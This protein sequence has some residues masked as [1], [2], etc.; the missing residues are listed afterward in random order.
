LPQFALAFL[1]LASAPAAD[2]IVPPPAAPVAVAPAALPAPGPAPSDAAPAAVAG[3]PAP[4]P[5]A[6]PGVPDAAA[7]L[8]AAPDPAAIVV[9]SDGGDIVV[10]AKHEAPREDPLEGVNIQSYEAVQAVDRAIVAP[11][12]MGYKHVIPK[13]VRNGISN[14]INNLDEPVV[15]LNYLLQLKPGKAAETLGRFAINSTIGV[16]G[17][18]DVAK[19][20]PFNL[21][22]RYNGLANTLGFY[23]IGPGPFLFLPGIG[24]TTVR[25]LFG[26]VADF[27][28][29]PRALGSPLTD[30]KY[31]LPKATLTAIS[32]R[33]DDDARITALRDHTADG[34][35]SI[36]KFYLDRRQAEIDAL[37]GKTKPA[38]VVVSVT[39]APAPAAAPAA[40]APKP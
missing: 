1:L 30:T 14:F 29:I 20:K 17:L 12:A 27:S 21:P 38:D 5:P 32:D 37:R 2:E 15:A 33:I 18:V 36:R 35:G 4:A 24:P 31:S 13:P 19:K 23:G 22:R 7:A 8:P 3:T 40:V 39:P 9:D 34:Y 26:R 16:A 28:I 11:V 10:S 25:D 6:V